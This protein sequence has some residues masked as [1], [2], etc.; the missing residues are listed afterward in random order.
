MTDQPQETAV[1]T[2][3]GGCFWCLE[4]VFEQVKGVQLVESGYEGGHIDQPSYRQVCGG[5]TGH[6]E[7]VRITFDPTV[8]SFRQLLEIFFVIHDP[9]TLNRQG[10]DV[11][12]Q[13]RSVI[14]THHEEQASVARE[15]IAALEAENVYPN[16]IVT[17]VVPTTTFFKAEDY[18]QGYFRSH[19]YEGYCQ[20]VVSPKVSKFRKTFVELQ[21]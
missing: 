17:Q 2:L 13:Y 3:G 4:A 8:I 12:T 7:V 5:S 15:V 10:A 1:A 14:F 16:P 9:T 21:K 6:A 11:G 19:P 20:V 18:H